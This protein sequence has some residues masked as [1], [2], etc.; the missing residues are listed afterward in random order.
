MCVAS[1][2]SKVQQKGYYEHFY[3]MDDELVMPLVITVFSAPNYCD[4]VTAFSGHPFLFSFER[5]HTEE[6]IWTQYENMGAVMKIEL[7]GDYNFKQFSWMDHPY[8]LPNFVEAFTFSV[9]LSAGLGK[10]QHYC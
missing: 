9:P 6:L 8:V 7:N 10:V 1:P 2:S 4:K 3:M 5:K